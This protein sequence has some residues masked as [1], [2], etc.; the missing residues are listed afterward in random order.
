MLLPLKRT[1]ARRKA[2][3]TAGTAVRAGAAGTHGLLP[4]LGAAPWR[5][6]AA[7]ADSERRVDRFISQVAPTWQRGRA[8]EFQ[9][10]G[11]RR[12]SVKGDP[13]GD[14]HSLFARVHATGTPWA[15]HAWGAGAMRGVLTPVVPQWGPT[16]PPH[17]HPVIVH[18]PENFAV[19]A[20]NRQ[21]WARSRISPVCAGAAK[22]PSAA[23]SNHNR[24][25]IQHQGHVP[26]VQ[27]R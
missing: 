25:D 21:I 3:G 22:P 6:R 1:R 4:V 5:P 16:L 2:R 8:G 10:Q 7:E 27:Q 19:K 12:G 23:H 15:R 14:C 18:R 11:A 13:G 9:R 24:H 26:G 17:C 20:Q